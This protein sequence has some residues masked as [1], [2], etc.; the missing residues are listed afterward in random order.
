MHDS[1]PVADTA[2]GLEGDVARRYFE[3]FGRLVREGREDSYKLLY[4]FGLR[5]EGWRPITRSAVG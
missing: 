5:P 4:S 3:V 2:R 1:G